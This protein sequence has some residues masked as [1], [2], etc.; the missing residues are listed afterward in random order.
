M[1][2]AGR[3]ETEDPL[4]GAGIIAEVITSGAE[5]VPISPGVIG[6]NLDDPAIENIYARVTNKTLGN[7]TITVTLKLIQ[8]EE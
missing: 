5:E 4:P 7:T 2:D 6:F 8:M 1:A 3:L